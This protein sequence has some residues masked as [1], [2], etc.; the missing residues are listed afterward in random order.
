MRF[1]K[2]VFVVAAAAVLLGP[3]AASGAESCPVCAAKGV[4]VET[5]SRGPAATQPA[6]QPA[7][8]AKL[9]LSTGTEEGKK[10]LV[11]TLTADGKAVQGARSSS[12]CSAPSDRSSLAKIRPWRTAS[13]RCLSRICP[14]EKPAN[15]V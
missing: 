1:L 5:A 14:V 13:P 7:N 4:A 15:F 6:T 9:T 2:I 3:P 11:A 12:W 8:G 10:V